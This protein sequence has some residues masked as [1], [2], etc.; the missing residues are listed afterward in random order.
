MVL[1]HSTRFRVHHSYQAVAN[2]SECH[3]DSAEK[4]RE[5]SLE[6]KP[7][8]FMKLYQFGEDTA[9]RTKARLNVSTGTQVA[10]SRPSFRRLNAAATW[11]GGA[12]LWHK[13][14]F[15]GGV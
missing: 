7:M 10:P 1:F 15:I 11:R 8:S 2:M 5:L 13:P 12:C 6:S 3:L 9:L 4:N 14:A